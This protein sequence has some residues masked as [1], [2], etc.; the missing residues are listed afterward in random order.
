MTA[1]SRARVSDHVLA[2]RSDAVM[3]ILT[4]TKGGFRDDT[5]IASFGPAHNG[6]HGNGGFAVFDEKGHRRSRQDADAAS[7][8]SADGDI[9]AE[10][11]TSEVYM[12]P[13]MS[14]RQ[15]TPEY[16]YD[17]AN[18]PSFGWQRNNAFSSSSEYLNVQ[19]AWNGGLD[20]SRSVRNVSGGLG[21]AAY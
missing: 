19:P 20:R 10:R 21:P 3:E 2:D 15:L 7:V 9:G 6:S 16:S 5:S 14:P 13:G 11:P 4:T 17:P 8:Y 1:V 18:R 12:R